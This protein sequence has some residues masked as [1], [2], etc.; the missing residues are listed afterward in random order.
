M[1]VQDADLSIYTMT[2]LCVTNFEMGYAHLVEIC[3]P[4]LPCRTIFVC[5]HPRFD[6]SKCTKHNGS[7]KHLSCKGRGDTLQV[8]IHD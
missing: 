3:I 2:M 1:Q 4:Q 7:E 6:L 8:G 5:G